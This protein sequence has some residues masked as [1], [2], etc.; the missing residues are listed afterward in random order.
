MIAGKQLGMEPTADLSIVHSVN[1]V[2]SVLSTNA[3]TLILLTFPCRNL[4]L[5]A[6]DVS[7][8]VASKVSVW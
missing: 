4:Q 8:L 7:I 2:G 5:I 1:V 3:T 6:L